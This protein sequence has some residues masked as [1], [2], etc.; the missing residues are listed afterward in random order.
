MGI[1][2]TDI[3]WSGIDAHSALGRTLRLPLRL[4]PRGTVIRIRRGPAK[5]LD[6]IVGSCTHGCWLGTYELQ[7]QRAM[8][9]FVKPRMTIYDIGAQAGFYTLFF[10][11]LVGSDGL[12]Y[13]FEP[14]ANAVRFLLAHVSRNRLINVKVVQTAVADKSGL[15]SFTFDRVT[16]ENMI[17]REQDT[18][19]M[20]PATTLD[21][22]RLA[23]PD[24]IKMDVE[25]A[26]SAVLQGAKQTIEHHRPILFIALHGR[27]QQEACR[28]ILWSAGY[29][30]YDLAGAKIEGPILADEIYAL[31]R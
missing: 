15:C 9:R 24:L 10:S 30:L 11:R 5:G 18:G 19:L 8:M 25:G 23:S 26:E 16:T 4:I 6:W 13:A 27:D 14:S 7:K 29:R 3:A 21:E 20:V 22:I 1:K 28:E 31:P 17:S 2:W 12:V